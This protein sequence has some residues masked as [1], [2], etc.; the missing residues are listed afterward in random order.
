MELAK[1]TNPVAAHGCA[2]AETRCC[3]LGAP[4]TNV[5]LQRKHVDSSRRVVVQWQSEMTNAALQT[6]VACLDS[7]GSSMRLRQQGMEFAVWAF[8]HAE[9]GQLEANAPLLLKCLREILNR[10]Q[11]CCEGFHPCCSP[12]IALQQAFVMCVSGGLHRIC[13]AGGVAHNLQICWKW[14]PI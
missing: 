5:S 8:K 1:R 14:Q 3:R 9:T 12:E 6:I 10:G 4:S 11:P 2:V 7:R 13:Y